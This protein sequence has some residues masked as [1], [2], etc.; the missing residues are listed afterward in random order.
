M[1]TIQIANRTIAPTH[2]TFVIAEIGVNH[3]GSLARAL[4]LVRIAKDGGADCVKLQIF[5][6]RTLMNAASAF[7][8][9]Q[10]ERVTDASPADM[11]RRYELSPRD[12]ARVVD[13]IIAAGL[14][15]LAT[16]FSPNDVQ[17]IAS[18]DLP[19][20]KIAS[21]D[22]V[23]YPLLDAVAATR[24]PMLLSTGAATLDEVRTSVAWLNGWNTPFALLHCVS[25]YPTPPEHANLQWIGELARAFNVP[26]GY[27]DHTPELLSG[28]LAVASGACLVERHLTYDNAAEGPDHSASSDPEDFAEYVGLIRTADL[29][30]GQAGKRVLPIEQDVRTVSR[31]SL[32]AARDIAAGQILSEADLTVQR[33]GTGI[34]AAHLPQTLGRR[35]QRAIPAGTMLQP[36]MLADAASNAA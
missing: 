24:R 20:V 31:Q 29:L 33:P 23:N 11:L 16:P 19:A 6:A 15:P 18:L 28:A 13:A 3:D 5:Q 14:V 32:V 36:D 9:Y 25:S 30:R 1:N 12:L 17:T 26:V 35:T 2:P 7:A 10:K 27:S 34:A 4:D 22:L 8:G 21:P